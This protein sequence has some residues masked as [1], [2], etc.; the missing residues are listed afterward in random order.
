MSYT[1]STP[2]QPEP[3]KLKKQHKGDKFKKVSKA[4]RD[5]L[6]NSPWITKSPEPHCVTSPTHSLPV[7]E[8]TP[9]AFRGFFSPP[10]QFTRRQ[11]FGS[12]RHGG[13][14]S[15]K[16]VLQPSEGIVRRRSH[17]GA[18]AVGTSP[19]LPPIPRRPSLEWPSDPRISALSPWEPSM[20]FEPTCE[21]PTGGWG[22]NVSVHRSSST[23]TTL[24]P[25]PLLTPDSL[26]P[27]RNPSPPRFRPQQQPSVPPVLASVSHV[28]Q[29]EAPVLDRRYSDLTPGKLTA[30]S[31]RLSKMRRGPPVF[32]SP[33]VNSSTASPEIWPMQGTASHA[34]EELAAE[35]S[36]SEEVPAVF[37]AST[38][39]DRVA[40][41]RTRASMSAASPAAE[42]ALRGSNRT[43]V[44]KS[45][46][47]VASPSGFDVSFGN[48]SH[49]AFTP[50]EPPPDAVRARALAPVAAPV[51]PPRNPSRPATSS[52]SHTPPAGIYCVRPTVTMGTQTPDWPEAPRPRSPVLRTAC[53]GAAWTTAATT[54]PQASVPFPVPARASSYSTHHSPPGD[55][56]A[57]SPS[58]Y[59]VASFGGR[60]HQ[61]DQRKLSSWYA[62]DSVD[63]EEEYLSPNSQQAVVA[64]AHGYD[65]DKPIDYDVPYLQAHAYDVHLRPYDIPATPLSVSRR[66]DSDLVP[67]PLMTSG[68]VTP[69]GDR[70]PDLTPTPY[71]TPMFYTPMFATPRSFHT[72]TP[73]L[74]SKLPAVP[75][76]SH[77]PSPESLP[78]LSRSQSSSEEDDSRRTS[79]SSRSSSRL[80]E[81][82]T[83]PTSA[84]SSSSDFHADAIEAVPPVV[85]IRKGSLI[86]AQSYKASLVSTG[87][88]IGRKSVSFDS[89][90]ASSADYRTYSDDDDDDDALPV[91][92]VP[93]PI[94]REREHAAEPSFPFPAESLAR[95]PPAAASRE[96]KKEDPFELR[97]R[98]FRA[99]DPALVV[100]SHSAAAAEEESSALRLRRQSESAAIAL[101]R[102]SSRTPGGRGPMTMSREE[103]AA[104][105]R[106][107]FLVQAL[108]GEEVPRGGMIRDWARS[109][110]DDDGGSA[111]EL[112][113]E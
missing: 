108:M 70:T 67:S 90:P 27:T 61:R 22:N 59:S 113:D 83:P 29:S 33:V 60:L 47:I 104:K 110:D 19:P 7:F 42:S 96:N 93:A 92:K 56:T 46:T 87:S 62:P 2:L 20:D 79:L 18:G 77:A 85:E 21:T 34:V 88:G 1:P 14:R 72:P 6:A 15:N 23:R 10:T 101:A 36:K 64:S 26:L 3:N 41:L 50:L 99:K 69:T 25:P 106:S 66:P 107:Y 13:G 40:T 43:D 73:I 102:S 4:L 103:R 112:S 17:V 37:A 86:T 95:S 58:I 5:S 63:E 31:K 65:D 9:S 28:R 45:Y 97:L 54:P 98:L 32:V 11:S 76:R 35:Q 16:P 30:A 44:N 91:P 68:G 75:D 100:R 53:K 105:G 71:A 109:S 12:L 39:R 8:T 111:S 49:T 55:H 52:R 94:R 74:T 82:F 89:L 38:G 51:P 78:S 80:S 48:P 24:S 57:R 84:A 81:P